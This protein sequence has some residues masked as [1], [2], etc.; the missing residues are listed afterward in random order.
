MSSNFKL[1]SI[2][3]AICCMSIVP[4][5]SN[6]AALSVLPS[7]TTSVGYDDNI[8]AN[9]ANKLSASTLTINPNFLITAETAKTFSAFDLNIVNKHYSQSSL[10][11]VLDLRL[12]L[13]TELYFDVRN[14]LNLSASHTMAESIDNLFDPNNS[15][16]RFETNTLGAEYFFGAPNAMF[17]IE[18]GVNAIHFRSP[19]AGVNQDLERDTVNLNTSLLTRISPRTQIDL[20]L[21]SSQVDY[22]L[23]SANVKNSDTFTY[24]LGLRWEATALTTGSFKIGQEKRRFVD[25]SSKPSKTSATW[26]L[27][28]I[29]EP[30]SYSRVSLSAGQKFDE[31]SFG[32]NYAETTR[33]NVSWNHD[34][35]HNLNSTVNLGLTQEAFK[36]GT[37]ANRTDKTYTAGVSFDYQLRYWLDLQAGYTYSERSSVDANREFDRN[38]LNLGVKVTFL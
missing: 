11:D 37:S 27:G 5:V 6:A 34:W 33:T 2:A 38:Q 9:N 4:L 23:A 14:Q 22:K 29:W 25:D 1:N 15:V 7:M 12:A 3:A 26:E 21:R 30:L 8:R 10:D 20:T 32:Y 36:E 16:E 13:D 28:A 17:N 31:G 35:R 18:A 19:D 24:L